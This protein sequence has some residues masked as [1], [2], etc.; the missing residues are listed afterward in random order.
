MVTM[1][2]HINTLSNILSE[3]SESHQTKFAAWCCFPFTK[4]QS[5]LNFL[6]LVA[7]A[8][9]ND[10]CMTIINLAWSGQLDKTSAISHQQTVD[11]IDWDP[12]S[13][14]DDQEGGHQGATDFLAAMSFFLQSVNITNAPLLLA[15]CAENLI[16]RIDYLADFSDDE[17][18]EV[19]KVLA[20]L[21]FENQ[22]RF[23]SDLVQNV[24]ANDDLDKYHKKVIEVFAKQT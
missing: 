1:K 3:T 14:D 12:E 24:I 5:V 21:E 22:T 7:S 13:V 6:E 17:D 18:A 20:E 19:F 4:D 23:A 9:F 8:E 11:S 2:Q 10:K 15:A 16:N